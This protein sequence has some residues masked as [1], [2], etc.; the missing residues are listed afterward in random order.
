MEMDK[1]YEPQ[2]IHNMLQ[3]N[4]GVRTV[5]GRSD[6]FFS[7]RSVKMARAGGRADW[8]WSVLIADFDND[9]W[10]DVHIT[11]GLGRDPTN[12]DF[13]EYAH[14]TVLETGIPENDLGQRRKFMDR[15]SALGPLSLRSYLFRNK[16]DLT[17]EDVSTGAGITATSISNG[18]VYADLDNDGDLDLVTNNINGRAFVLR[19]DSKPSA[20]S[21]RNHY[22]TI[23]LAGDTLNRDGIGS[24]V[25][26][27]QQSADPDGQSISGQRLFVDG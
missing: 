7:A 9:G 19:N 23:R 16:G 22:L 11:N 20:G 10:K 4:N 12:I 14:N 15:L 6:A 21:G 13:L 24:V 25:C 5:N 18:A 8:S 3:L 17:F 1:G 26:C 27:L 2:Y